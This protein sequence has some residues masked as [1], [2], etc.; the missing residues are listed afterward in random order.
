MNPEVKYNFAATQKDSGDHAGSECWLPPAEFARTLEEKGFEQVA[1]TYRE[2]VK[3]A[4]DVKAAGGRALIVG[5][6]VRD[7]FLGQV[8]KDIDLEVYHLPLTK[9]RQVVSRGRRTN[10][11]G[12]AFGVLKVVVGNGLD[13]DIAPPR[14]DS[15]IGEGHRGFNTEFDPDLSITEA[16]RRRDFTMNS[17]GVDPLTGE[18]FDPFGGREDIRQR[19]LRVTDSEKFGEDPLRILRA[20]QFAG[21]FQMKLEPAS[22]KICQE[23]L[24]YVKTL[25]RER[26]YQEWHKLLWKSERPSIGLDVGKKIGLFKKYYPE[27]EI[28]SSLPQNP[29]WH[30]EGDVWVHTKRV[31]DAMAQIIRREK[32]LE[33]QA[34]RLMFAALA[35]DLGKG[36]TTI[37]KEGKYV[38]YDH[39]KTGVEITKTFLE[40]LT[41]QTAWIKKILPLVAEHMWTIN[42]AKDRDKISDG[43]IRRLANRTAPASI[44]ELI[45]VGEADQR[46]CGVPLSQRREKDFSA[47]GKFILGDWLLERSKILGIEKGKPA[48]LTRGQDWLNWGCEKKFGKSIGELISWAEKLRDEQEYDKSQ[49]YEA[50][51]EELRA[52]SSG[53]L[54]LKKL[55]SLIQ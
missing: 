9:L 1:V 26:L 54:A 20:M 3:I 40:K 14:R 15:K 52:D 38:S 7:K 43:A 42:M 4:E 23:N 32:L 5:G 35:H 39:E 27:L 11:V 10:E 37:E 47:G 18:V 16:A 25:S 8:S 33:E 46:G 50:V 49:I 55:K 28:L 31:V 41:N 45:W 22:L 21:R 34:I 17:I 2:A 12:R 6:F 53:A 24:E 51:K 19:W 29:E 13:I 44:Q 30:P 36:N 48:L